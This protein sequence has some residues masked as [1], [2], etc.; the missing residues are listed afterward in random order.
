[1]YFLASPLRDLMRHFHKQPSVA[2]RR[3]MLSSPKLLQSV[4]NIAAYHHSLK[5]CGEA[6]YSHSSEPAAS[7]IPRV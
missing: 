6:L 2:Q 5:G 1:M 3:H 7:V 4:S